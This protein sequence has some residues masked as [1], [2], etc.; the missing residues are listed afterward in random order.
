MKVSILV[1]GVALAAGL[2]LLSWRFGGSRASTHGSSGWCPVWRAFRH[3]LF[4]K[5]G[6]RVGDWT[7]RLGVYHD[8]THAIT[9]GAAGAGKGA[10]AIVPNLLRMRAGFV[11]DPGGENAAVATK[12]LRERGVAV[13]CINVFG[14]FSEA[15]VSLPQQG[16][17]PLDFLSPALPSFAAD[18]LVFAE[19]LTPR[20]G[21]EGGS[22]AYFKD[23]AQRV[24]RALIVHIKTSAPPER[25]SL[26][27]LY[28]VVNGDAQTWS[29]LL[30]AMK[31]NTVCGGLVAQEANVLERIEAQAPQEFSAIM[32][33]IQQDLSF[34]ADPLVRTMLSRSDVDFSIL[35][36]RGAAANGG[37]IFVVLPLE[38][39]ESHAAIPRLALACAVLEMQRAPLARRKVH[40]LIDEA[41]ALGRILRLA[42]WHATLRKYRAAFWTIWQS[43]GQLKK[44][45]DHDA[46][47]I[48]GNCTL[49]QF[50]NFR[51]L[52]T[53]QYGE[54]FAGRTTVTTTNF[55][56]RGEAS[57]GEAG[58]PLIMADEL[59]RLPEGQQLAFI[60]NLPPLLLAKTPYWQQPD[61][62]GLYNA[63]P[64]FGGSLPE[65]KPRD[66][67][68]LLAGRVYYA[69]VCLLAPHR[70]VVAAVWL[71]A[72]VFVID[73][74]IF[75]SSEVED[76]KRVCTY[77]SRHGVE[78]YEGAVR[79]PLFLTRL[80]AWG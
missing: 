38:Y 47:T 7:G 76:G 46:E 21:N 77:V 65:P 8:A 18:A 4:R 45:Y 68:A 40:F 20:A 16:F 51:D 26:S 43:L 74:G 10:T 9:F 24:K 29:G 67:L 61:L 78:R 70:W 33:T 11:I 34:L 17:N 37:V 62:R 66:R 44:L 80:G 30:T 1:S 19:M 22:S 57:T 28:E 63:N 31:A 25:Q 55:N 3:G 58:R 64:Y 15:P 54:K 49:K 23:A 12:A 50:L 75:V 56:A 42:S 69:G 36:G 39:I 53:A 48:M 6:L 14:M 59:L 73:P 32:S 35:K 79:C 5:R 41:A 71:P 27:T 72:L 60:D 52:V 2:Y 13:G